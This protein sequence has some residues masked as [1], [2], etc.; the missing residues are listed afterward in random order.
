MKILGYTDK[1]S[2]RPGDTIDFKVSAAAAPYS[3]EFVRL[4]GV[5]V[6]GGD[7]TVREEKVDNSAAGIFMGRAQEL[8][9]G[10]YAIISP[11]PPPA[12]STFGFDVWVQPTLL[13]RDCQTVLAVKTDRA[14]TSWSLVIARGQLELR[15]GSKENANTL[16]ADLK[17][18]VGR[19]VHVAGGRNE[20]GL[21][22]EYNVDGLWPAQRYGEKKFLELAAAPEWARVQRILI[23]ANLDE[24]SF[25]IDRFNGRIENPS[26]LTAPAQE[27][28]EPIASWHFSVGIDTLAISDVSG[29][30]FHGRLVNRPVRGVRGRQW[31]GTK[32]RYQENPSEWSAIHFHE[33]D[34]NDAGWETDFKATFPETTPSGIYAAKITQGDQVEHLPF[35]VRP[36]EGSTNRI[37]FLAPTNTYLAYA[38]EHLGYG[39]RGEAHE[40][41]MR[42]KIQ[43]NEI[44][45]FI[46]T[47]PELGLS[48]Y[49]RH[50]DGSGVTHSSWKR[51]VVNFRP[52]YITW[53]NAARRHFAADF[54][55]I[56]WLE[57]FGVGFDVATD[58]DLHQSGM[59]LLSR[60]DVVVSGSHPEYPTSVEMDA[61]RAYAAQGGS[62][63]YLG[64]NGWYWVTSYDRGDCMTLECRRGYS[65]ERNWT[66]HPAE[67][68]HASTGEIGGLY[69]HRGQSSRLLFGVASAGVGWGTA[70]GYSRTEDSY[71]PELSFIFEGLG[72][73]MIGAFGYVLGGAAGDELDSADFSAGTPSNARVILSSRHNDTY[74]PFL[75][76]VTQVEPNV[77]GPFNPNVRS[78]VVFIDTGLGGG[79]L[80]VG[81][82]CWA[83]SLAFNNYD[84]NVA[85]LTSNVLRHFLREG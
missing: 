73:E 47:H 53:L 75:E 22:V 25:P 4:H 72:D 52:N 15:L 67:L 27:D 71:S 59:E 63:M 37:L 68:L 82:I 74:Y 28:G 85:K 57:T 50:A 77:S 56:G 30:G 84:N 51:P 24:R 17:N 42:D 39:E 2:I 33:D 40:K 26:F 23:G 14:E 8:R 66:S 60:Y 62:L 46:H 65:G 12:I 10:S 16:S 81:S 54:Y 44:D 41:R 58:A 11:E 5:S 20:H 18:C 61:L 64:G 3:V 13:D 38:N 43:L 69:S 36:T 79:I 70:S 55:I 1:I 48:I 76:S 31:M 21:V 80:S 83:G 49:D 29:N 7:Q 19:W 45:T 34:L 9:P 32:V 6:D 35:F 78:D